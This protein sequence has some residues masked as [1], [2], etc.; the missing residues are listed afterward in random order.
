MKSIVLTRTLL[1]CWS[2]SINLI[3]L[4]LLMLNYNFLCM[5]YAKNISAQLP[6]PLMCVFVCVCVRLCVLVCM[7]M[8][9]CVQGEPDPFLSL[10][11]CLLNNFQSISTILK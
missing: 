6:F 1:F 7:C 5:H 4:K 3:R 2:V 10:G 11:W 9:V 8:C